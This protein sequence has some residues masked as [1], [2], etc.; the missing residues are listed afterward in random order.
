MATALFG[1]CAVH[2]AV[3]E[4]EGD[5]SPEAVVAATLDEVQAGARRAIREEM[6]LTVP[7]Y[8]PDGCRSFILS[9]SDLSDEAWLEELRELTTVPWVTLTEHT[10]EIRPTVG[11]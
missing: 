4:W 1:H 9:D 2:V 3:I 6:A 10:V 8:D 11:Q 5:R 7:E